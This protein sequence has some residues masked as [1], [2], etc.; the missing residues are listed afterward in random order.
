MKTTFIFILILINMS[1][2][3]QWNINP[4]INNAVCN[5]AGSQ[6]NVQVTSDGAGG[7]ICTWVDTRNGSQDIYAQRID[8]SGS[9]QWNVDGIAICNA[10]SDQY[11]PRLVSDAAGGAIIVWYDNRAGNYDIYAQRINASGVVQWTADGVAIT[12][13][14]G[15][16]NAHQL[17][18][19]GS[20]GAIIVWSD[21]AGG[22]PNADI[23]AQ[24]INA[25]GTVLWGA[26]GASVCTASSLQNTPQLVSDGAGGAII[27]WEDWRSFSQPDIYAQRISSNG[28]TNWNFNGVLICSEPNFANQYSTKIVSDAAGGAIICWL[29]QRNFGSGQDIYAQRVNASGLVQWVNNGVIVCNATALQTAQQMIADGNGGTIITWEDRRSS[30]ADIY[31]QR[32]NTSGAAQWTANGI[33]I[34]SELSAQNEAQIVPRISGGATII[35]TD[36]RNSS[37]ADIYA[38]SITLAG[39]VLWAVDGVPVANESHSQFA[40]HLIADGADGAIIAWQDLRTT[41][42]YDI[43]SSKLFANGTLPVKLIS[44]TATLQNKN[45]LLQWQIANELNVAKYNIQRSLDGNSFTTIGAVNSTGNST[46]T[47]NY[48]YTDYTINNLNAGRIYYQLQMVDIDGKLTYSKIEVVKPVADMLVSI[49]PN[50]VHDHIIVS[51]QDNIKVL[52]IMNS[53]GQTVK[54]IALS[55]MMNR[56][57]IEIKELPA[58][59]YFVKAAGEKEIWTGQFIKQ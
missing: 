35:W 43:Y 31:A 22:G 21:G 12:T 46:E 27:S 14:P 28:F 17:I 16:Q 11:S 3:A 59:L 54:S 7:A 15:N 33:A 6:M 49:A 19:D 57:K 9:L 47:K 10:V 48:T 24:L 34:C 2:Y 44:F 5:Y 42:D 4:A 26:G 51:S 29:D 8:A 58:G 40:S 50:P 32:L 13:Q 56:Q 20:G 23:R 30:Q 1:I 45:A 36:I 55:G 52:I 37:Q 41:A 53:Q 18:A 25:L 39:A 38:Q